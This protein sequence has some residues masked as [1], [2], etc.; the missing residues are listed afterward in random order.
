MLI[1]GLWHGAS[2]TFVAWGA[3]HGLFL[4]AERIVQEQLKANKRRSIS[5][6]PELGIGTPKPV[7]VKASFLPIFL[8]RPKVRLLMAALITFFLVNVTWVFFRA[9]D[10]ETA[11]RLLTAMFGFAEKGVAILSTLDI[12]KVV[13]ITILLLTTHWFMRETTV[14]DRVRNLKW[15]QTGLAWGLI[16]IILAISQKSSDSFIYFQF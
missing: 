11:G 4:S 15:W 3:L 10:F 12:I 1:G 16:L 9:S 5:L 2:W 14:L 13:A 6:A 8:N 7:T